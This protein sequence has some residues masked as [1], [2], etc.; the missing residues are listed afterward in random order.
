MA[1]FPTPKIPFNPER[2]V[3]YRTA[4]ELILDGKLDEIDWQN[5]EWTKS[6]VDIEG[7]LKPLPHFDT[8]VKLLWDETYFYVGVEMEEAH[9]R[10]SP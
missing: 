8:K 4:G 7:S 1:E 5:A 10:K 2:Y 3:C 9:L 6:F